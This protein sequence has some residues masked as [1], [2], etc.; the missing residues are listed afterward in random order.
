MR[1]DLFDY[2]LPPAA[3]A[4]RPAEPRDS[5][6]LLD[7]RDLGDHRFSDLPA[8]LREGDLV[9]VNRTRVRRARLRGR[10]VPTGGRV[11]VLLL[12]PSGRPDRWDA[13]VR[14]ARRLH[15]GDRLDLGAL[16]AT[17]V[18]AP[19][20]GVVA[21]E[22]D[23]A[24]D[25]EEAIAAAGEVPLPPYITGPLADPDRYQTI[26]ADR[27]GSA[28]APTA[29]LHF[30]PAVVDGLRAAGIG[31]ASVDLEVGLGT[32][33]PISAADVEDHAIHRE[34]FRLDPGTAEAVA[35]ARRRGGRVV[36]VGT[37]VTRV[38]EAQAR[39]GGLVA[40]G[41]GE[42]ALYLRPGNGPAVVD[43]L[44]TNFHVPRSSLVVLVASFMGD[45]WREAYET[46]LARGYRFLS[47]GDAMLCERT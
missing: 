42:T 33:R 20:E 37:T 41:E 40:A 9:V 35:A 36:A 39:P 25:V 5:A 43:V 23:A 12:G 7:T 8:L 30:T 38:L 29:G 24:G 18:T 1:T 4:Q 31:L 47:F 45:R 15:P 2:E 19:V 34:R 46:A 11:E 26:F 14:P 32:F 17:V 22:L 27:P 21:V 16:A 13:L 3:I 44:V 28:A 10:K 6:R